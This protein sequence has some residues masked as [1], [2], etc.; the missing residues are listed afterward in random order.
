MIAFVWGPA[1]SLDP[2]V[3]I[4]LLAHFLILQ[5]AE[6]IGLGFWLLVFASARRGAGWAHIVTFGYVAI[7]AGMLFINTL[8]GAEIS[9]FAALPGLVLGVHLVV[10]L[11]R[12]RDRREQLAAAPQ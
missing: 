8:G 11:R 12:H 5:G 4:Q 3:A 7:T 2:T 6:P 10:A 9:W 1:D